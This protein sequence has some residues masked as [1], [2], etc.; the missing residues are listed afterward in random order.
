MGSVWTWFISVTWLRHCK[1]KAGAYFSSLILFSSLSQGWEE[2]MLGMKKGG[3]R[4]IIIPPNL[5]Y[6]SKGVPNRV[7]ANSTLIFEAEPR[8]VTHTL[9]LTASLPRLLLFQELLFW[10]DINWRSLFPRSS[11]L[12]TAAL[13][14]PA[15]APETQLPP[16]LLPLL[17]LPRPQVW[18]IWLQSPQHRPQ[19]QVQADQGEIEAWEKD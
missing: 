5:A 10:K 1:V 7:P 4:L 6:G 14:E 9:I 2:G 16:P 15:L 11:L 12:G 17:L 8:R 18:R 13:T 3:R 19:P